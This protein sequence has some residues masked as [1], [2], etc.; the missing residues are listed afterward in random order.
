MKRPL[1][2]IIGAVIVLVLIG[3]WVYIVFFGQTT[4]NQDTYANLGIGDTTDPSYVA[5]SEN[6][7]EKT[8]VIDVATN[9]RLRQ[10]TT[11]PV[12]GYREVKTDSTETVLL[13]YTEKGTGHIYSIDLQSGEEK[14]VSA[15][16]IPLS[17]RS[18]ITPN[19]LFTL[20]QSNN[21]TN[22]RFTLGT[23]STTSDI[24]ITEPIDEKI[25]AFTST[26]DNKFLYAVKTNNSVIAKEFNPVSK[27]IKDLFTVPVRE[28][29]IVW[30][31][32]ANMSHLFYPK[33]STELE[34]FVYQVKNSKN[35][36]LPIDGYGVSV[37]GTDTSL[38]YSKKVTNA[39]KSYLFSTTTPEAIESPIDIIPEKCATLPESVTVV[40]CAGSTKKLDGTM[41]DSWYKGI[42]PLV[43][44]LWSIN[45]TTGTL[46]LL[47]AVTNETG[48][49]I[50]ISNLLFN[51]NG[52]RLYF[53][54][55]SSHN[56]WLFELTSL[57]NQ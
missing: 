57:N 30:G 12:A 36:R 45:T 34:G 39:Y 40:L 33:A 15:T 56:L 21:G 23:I 10:L 29:A 27:T 53:T 1:F 24:L 25:I 26:L 7:E 35:T 13:Y 31:N 8:P 32:T 55:S 16:T 17:Y 11:R 37:Y 3:V 20:V 44:D 22:A 28:A 49:Q 41:P 48:R 51:H 50:D 18:T 6:G 54:D 43:D 19:G 47:S 4:T 46:E 42:V 52:S 14:R 38:I 2:I 5:P 9:Q